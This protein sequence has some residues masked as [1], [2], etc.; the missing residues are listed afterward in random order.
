MKREV[1]MGIQLFSNETIRY[2]L[3]GSQFKSQLP[4]HDLRTEK[5]FE[6][7]FPIFCSH[8]NVAFLLPCD[9]WNRLQGGWIYSSKK[10]L[11]C[12]KKKHKTF[13]NQ[14]WW[15]ILRAT[16]NNWS[17]DPFPGGDIISCHYQDELVHLQKSCKCI[18]H[19][20]CTSEGQAGLVKTQCDYCETEHLTLWRHTK[21]NSSLF[22]ISGDYDIVILNKP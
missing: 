15:T 1:D 3:T 22:S 4:K 16:P 5:V 2:I 8:I 10:Y 9:G 21:L 7:L 19:V 20:V 6:K 11:Q 12:L 14:S 17:C 18:L 13:L